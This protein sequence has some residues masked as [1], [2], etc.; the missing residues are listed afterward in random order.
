VKRRTARGT[1]T[2][3]SPSH[4]V[5]DR[6]QLTVRLGNSL[7]LG[8][9]VYARGVIRNKKGSATFAT[10]LGMEKV[11]R[12]RIGRCGGAGLAGVSS[13]QSSND[14]ARFTTFSCTPSSRTGAAGCLRLRSPQ[15]YCW[16][17][18]MR[19]RIYLTWRA[20]RLSH[21]AS[22]PGIPRNQPKPADRVAQLC[23]ACLSFNRSS[24][25]PSFSR[26]KTGRR[27]CTP[28]AQAHGTGFSHIWNP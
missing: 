5:Q 11:G 9:R 19:P 28:R 8:F 4:R 26:N 12:V 21:T 7:G 3:R 2:L 13:W 18:R 25:A 27:N 1:I 15:R 20:R 10:L 14:S 22:A 24:Y 17:A 23:R 6:S 16:S